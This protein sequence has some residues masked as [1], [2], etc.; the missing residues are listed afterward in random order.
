MVEADM[1]EA[2]EFP[3]LA[4][5]FSVSGV[6]QTTIN[7]GAKNVIGAVPENY[8]LEQIKLVVDGQAVGLDGQRQGA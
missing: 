3:E 7:A 5:K 4:E 6:P 8:L 2:M 1:I